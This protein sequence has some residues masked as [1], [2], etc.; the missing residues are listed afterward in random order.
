MPY[1]SLIEG[2]IAHAHA[3]AYDRHDEFFWAYKQLHDLIEEK[4]TDAWPIVVE[5]VS[6]VTSDEALEYVAAD[7]L[8]DLICRDPEGLIDGIEDLAR[9]DDHF[10]GALGGVWGWTRIPNEV[11]SRLEVLVG[12]RTNNETGRAG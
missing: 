10:R 7:V 9:K 12:S 4:P 5:V 11:R 8:E 6:R 2:Y 1:S 3:V